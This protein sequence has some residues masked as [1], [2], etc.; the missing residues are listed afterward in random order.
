MLLK[1][2]SSLISHSEL[3]VSLSISLSSSSVCSTTFTGSV[4]SSCSSSLSLPSI[5]FTSTTVTSD[6][7]K[8]SF[9]SRP[10]LLFGIIVKV[11][12]NCAP[13]T[14]LIVLQPWN[15]FKQMLLKT[16]ITFIFIF[17]FFRLGGNIF[18]LPFYPRFS[19]L[20]ERYRSSSHY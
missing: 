3:F 2:S 18:L 17:S 12:T 7:H 9:S 13:H 8:V 14:P 16:T 6:S 20:G 1:V 5:S 11:A 19:V 15:F 10:L 4:C